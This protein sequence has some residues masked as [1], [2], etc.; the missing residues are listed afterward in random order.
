[1]VGVEGVTKVEPGRG[2]VM[3]TTPDGARV[4]GAVAVALHQTEGVTLQ[5]L[6]LRRPTLDDVFLELTGAHLR[7][8]EASA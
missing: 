1:V 3:V 8:E 2:E 5:S 7:A 4:I 6:S